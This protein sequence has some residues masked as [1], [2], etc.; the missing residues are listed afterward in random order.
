VIVTV[1]NGELNVNFKR[2]ISRWDRNRKEVKV[3]I[4]MPDLASVEFSGAAK[5]KVYGFDQHNMD[6]NLSG[7]A[8]TDMDVT[9]TEAKIKLEGVS[10]L[11]LSGRGESLEAEIHGASSLDAADYIVDYAVIDA[12]GASKV[13]IHAVKELSI[14]ASGGSSVRYIGDPMITSERSTASSIIKE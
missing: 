5:C 8:V 11:N 3:F 1:S 12:A 4:T 2:D 14:D 6:I 13:R 10:R 9:L 7:A